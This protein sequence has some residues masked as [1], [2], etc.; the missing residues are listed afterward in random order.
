MIKIKEDSLMN[1]FQKIEE[2]FN[3]LKVE[4]EKYLNYGGKQNT[5]IK[6]L[7]FGERTRLAFLKLNHEQPNLYIMDEPTNHL[8]IDA[9]MKLEKAILEN[10]NPCIFVSHDRTFVERVANKYYMINDKEKVLKPINSTDVFFDILLKRME[11][12]NGDC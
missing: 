9:Q 1:G 3:E 8:D 4:V 6:E 10:D 12:G 2:E 5:L 7:S 11:E